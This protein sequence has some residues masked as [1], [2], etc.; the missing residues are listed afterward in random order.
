VT[1]VLHITTASAWEEARAAGA[2][3][4]PSLETEGFV[5]CSSGDQ[6][7][8][9][10]D[11]AF[12]GT[13]DLVLLCVETE[14]LGAPVRWEPGDRDSAESFPHVY[15]A[16]E[17]GAVVAVVPFPEGPDGFALPDTE[18]FETHEGRPTGRPSDQPR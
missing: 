16:I 14:R 6:V 1:R 12:R 15:G 11:A 10:A 5:H 17:A 18:A 2:Y 9:V 8:R 7:V 13:G 3:R 4:P